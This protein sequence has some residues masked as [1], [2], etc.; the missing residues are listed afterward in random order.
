VSDGQLTASLATFSIQVQAAPPPAGSVTLSW[1]APTMNS[2]GSQ[3]T[4]LVGYNIRYGTSQG[5]LPNVVNVRDRA[6]LSYVVQNLG[7]GTYFFTLTAVNAS[8]TESDPSNVA[9]KTVQ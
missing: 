2:D 7:A 6:A 5:N 8:G 1:T 3:L 9:S 4:D